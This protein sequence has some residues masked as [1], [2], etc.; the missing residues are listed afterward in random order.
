[1]PETLAIRHVPFEDLGLLAPLLAERE[2]R[3]HYVEA[4]TTDLRAIDA[5][6]PDLLV[7]LGGPIS[8]YD[9][10]R[11]PFLDGEIALLTE[12]LRAKRPTLGICLGAQLMACALGARVYPSGTKEVG[13][14]PLT[15][16]ADGQTSC[17][18]HLANTAVLH[19]H[20]DTFDLPA[21]AVHLAATNV[22]RNQAFSFGAHALALQFHAEAFGIALETWF[23]GHACEIAA[24]PDLTVPGLRA[25]TASHSETLERQGGACFHEWLESQG[26]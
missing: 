22:C 26:L 18:R 1:M 7:V 15:L 24:T 19:W 4:P 17:L 11:Y 23:V 25:A 12:R 6:A 16:S 3:V 21:G 9:N 8:V 13:W 2:H 20:G 14:A 10:D 5:L